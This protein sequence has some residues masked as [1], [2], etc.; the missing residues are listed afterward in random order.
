[1]LMVA[2]DC[3]LNCA[4]CYEAHKDLGRMEVGLA[5]ELIEREFARVRDDERFD[6]LEVDFMGGEPLMN[7]ELIREVVE[8][9]ESR[10]GVVPFICFATTN[11]TL[12]D[13]ERKTWFRRHRNAVWLGAS[14]DGTEAMQRLNRGASRGKIDLEF[15]RTTWPEQDFHMTVSRK[16]LPYLAQGVISLQRNGYRIASAL[17]QGEDWS[18]EDA[19]TYY[20]Q[21]VQLA[22]HYLSDGG[23]DLIPLNVLDRLVLLTEPSVGSQCKYCGSGDHMITYDI[24]GKSYPCHM[25]T[26]TVMGKSAVP[27]DDIDL[28][29]DEAVRDPFCDTCVLRGYCP[30]CV[31]FNYRYR[32]SPAARDRRMCAM[33]LAEAKAASEF[34]LKAIADERLGFDAVTARHAKA[35][36]AASGMLAPFGLTNSKPPFVRHDLQEG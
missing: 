24:D 9:L 4:Y 1:M 30:T 3:N 22:E 7:F 14:V 16:T 10:R 34:Q 21:L 2:H 18:E 15:F 31:G 33:T 8:W 19:R 20:G 36:L 27:C 6:E 5:K 17:A 12:L 13:E 32:G 29:S 25:F 35:A 11:G 28:T 26:P 23:A